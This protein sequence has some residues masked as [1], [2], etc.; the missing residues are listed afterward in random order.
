MKT[1]EDYCIYKPK[2]Q[3]ELLLG[4]HRQSKGTYS[5]IYYHLIPKF[6][7]NGIES[8]RIKTHNEVVDSH[9]NFSTQLSI[10]LKEHFKNRFTKDDWLTLSF[11]FSSI[12]LLDYFIDQLT[13]KT[14]LRIKTP[15]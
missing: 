15:V 1:N 6:N 5:T 12:N 13:V 10:L 7:S 14:M 3:E 2:D 9:L 11:D 8:F 4:R